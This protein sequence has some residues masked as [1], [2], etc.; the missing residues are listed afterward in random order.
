MTIGNTMF[1]KARLKLTGWYLLIIMVISMAFSVSVFRILTNELTRIERIQR[2]RQQGRLSLQRFR[3]P[4]IDPEVLEETRKRL[5]V[6]LVL[7]NL[8]IL[9]ASALAGYFLA[10]KT[11]KPIKRMVDEQGR[12]I[13]DASHELRTP[14]TSLK[15][16]IEV[17][18]RDKRLNL[19]DA[20][21]LLISNLEEVNNL[22]YLSDNLIKLA[23][24]S[25]ENSPR[26]YQKT[27]NR[28]SFTEVS[29]ME[30]LN[31]AQK[32]VANLAKNRNM[33]IKNNIKDQKVWGD[34]Q[35]LIEMFV[36]FLDNAIKFSS[37]GKTITL[38]SEKLDGSV[39]IQIKDQGFGVDEENI[40]HIFDRFY[41]ADKSRTKSD[42]SGYGL[43]LSIAKQIAD[44]HHGSIKVESKINKGTT[45]FIQLSIKR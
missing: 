20:K 3:Q 18:L 38:I 11:L 22:Q 13:T 27:D 6:T 7:I 23:Q 43:G 29:L 32:K 9:G 36:I 39:E 15:S 33:N 44:K 21:K 5:G 42:I 35:S 31:E 8:G 25:Q 4:S 40:P 1:Q 45:F 16:E 12:F 24:F 2:L 28:H 19:T 14:L 37:K 26:L 41:R 17:N 34:K 10:G 30:I